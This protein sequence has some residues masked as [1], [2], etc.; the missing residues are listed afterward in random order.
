MDKKEKIILITN[1]DGIASKGIKALVEAAQGFGNIV[2]IAPHKGRSAMS[3]AITVSEPLEINY[4]GK[5]KH[6][7]YYSCTGTPADCVKLGIHELLTQKPDLVLSG[8]N[9]G[10]N[11]STSV[12]YSGTMAGA[13]EGAL[14]R[15]SSIGFSLTDYHSDA[16]FDASV[17][18]AKRIIGEVLN[19]GLPFGICL[20]IN[21]PALKIDEL[22]GV[23]VCRQAKGWWVENFD[24]RKNPSG[25]EYYWLSGDF[26][27]SEPQADDTDEWCISNGFASVVPIKIDFTDHQFLKE[28]RQWELGLGVHSF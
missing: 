3:H 14:N 5:D 6:A 2:V 13:I 18:I 11:T 27:N 1:D 24:K 7:T 9:H 20:N 12:I 22:K 10:P 28:L 21:I 23:K 26:Y 16:D 15:I 19:N 17:L 25:K 8:I 4:Y